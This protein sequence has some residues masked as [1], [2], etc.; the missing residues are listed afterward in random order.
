MK[1]AVN[2]DWFDR[3]GGHRFVIPI[4][5]KMNLYTDD[6]E[7]ADIVWNIDSI[8]N[9]GLKKGKKLTI[10]WELDDYMIAGRNNVFYD[11]PDL[12]YIVHPEYKKYYPEKAKILRMAAE[13]SFHYERDVPKDFDYCFVSSLEPLPVYENRIYALDRLAKRAFEIGQTILVGYGSREDYPKL[14][15]RGKVILDILPYLSH[16]ADRVCIHGRLYESM[17]VGCLM[18]DT[19]PALEA[20]FEKDK[21]Y[22]DIERFGEVTD[23][24]IERVKKASREEILAKHTWQHRV[25]QVLADIQAEGGEI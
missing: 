11:D 2:T 10:Y 4:L 7:N 18:V 9:K 16:P 17:A 19:N 5:K 14:L 15:S 21:H 20:I 3:V 6:L 1:I 12:L 24:E 25:D 22:L 13:P 8:H 23:E